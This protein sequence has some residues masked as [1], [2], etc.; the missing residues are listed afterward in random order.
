MRP[1]L[2]ET[3][4]PLRLAKT[5]NEL[6]GNYDLQQFGR[7]TMSLDGNLQNELSSQ[8]VSF[9]LEFCQIIIS[10]NDDNRLFSI[11]GSVKTSLPQVCQ[12]CMRPMRQQVNGLINMAIVSNEEEAE[13]L[14]TEFEAYI[15]TG[16]PVKLQ[17]FIED[18]L[19][20]AM[21]LVPLHEEQECPAADVFKHKQ[22]AK[23]NPF[24][25]LKNLK[26]NN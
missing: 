12:R 4:D 3:I 13:D 11:V 15:D 20:L 19:L 10:G 8:Q 25:E 18:E 5:G 16:V 24:A 22:A 23:K 6:S 2:P 26:L 1:E 21:P 7:V 17:D 14:P 9:R